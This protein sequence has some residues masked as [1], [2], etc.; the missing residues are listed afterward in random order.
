MNIYKNNIRKVAKPV[1]F[2]LVLM[3][4]MLSSVTAYGAGVGI[5]KVND[6]V[7]KK[8]QVFEALETFESNYD[9][10]ETIYINPEDDY[11]PNTV[12]VNEDIMLLGNGSID[13]NVPVGTRYVTGAIWLT[14]GTVVQI[15]C[16]G[17]PADCTYWFGLMY[18]SSA[19]AVAEGCGAGA[20]GFTVPSS[21]LYRILV[22]NRSSQVIHVVGGY[23][24]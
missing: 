12:Y 13:W 20:R 8:T 21:G 3:F 6:A 10:D 15:A 18:P 2:M 11:V 14:E 23:Q 4:A 17:T 22:E 24:Y 16:T 7:L 5:A 9:W 19:L 1:T